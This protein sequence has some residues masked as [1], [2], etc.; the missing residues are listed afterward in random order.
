MA[1]VLDTAKDLIYWERGKIIYLQGDMAPCFY[2]INKGK[3]QLLKETQGRLF[4]ISVLGDKEFIGVHEAILQ[5]PYQNTAMAL[6]STI[7]LAIPK[8]DIQ[9]FLKKS[10]QWVERIVST[11]AERLKSSQEI[12]SD[13]QIRSDKFNDHRPF[14]DE[15]ETKFKNLIIQEKE[16]RVEEHRP[17]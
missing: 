17:S 4:P 10:P 2:I 5:T 12:V 7:L 1:L 16:K 9:D 14:T 13:Y 8:K 15:E 3:V 6:T 11:L